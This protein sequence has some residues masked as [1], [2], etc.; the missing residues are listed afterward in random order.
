MNEKNASS[1]AAW[2]L[3]T[4]GV[5]SARVEAHRLKLLTQRAKKL[6]DQSDHK[7]HLHQVAGDIIFGIPQRLEA[8]EM[9]LDRTSLAL[10]KMGETFLEA[11]LPLGDKNQVEEA[12]MPA[13]GG[14]TV[15]YATERRL[16]SRLTLRYLM[17]QLQEG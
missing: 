4:E 13:F 17:A 8:L 16:I 7:E 2:A 12:T 10:S 5:V 3:I 1:Q 11:R 14:G 9:D 15:R 6:V